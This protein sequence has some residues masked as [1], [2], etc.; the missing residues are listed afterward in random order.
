VRPVARAVLASFRLLLAQSETDAARLADLAG[1]AVRCVGNLKRAAPPLPHDDAALTAVRARIA[2]R[3]VWL[4]ASTHPG[5]EAM[6][7]AAHTRL[8]SRHP[9]LV[10]VIVPRHPTRGAAIR[11]ALAAT[12]QGAGLRS[13][14]SPLGEDG[15]YVADT[16]GELGLWYRL[17]DVAF[18]GGSL[19]PHGGQNPLEGARLGCALVYGPAMANFGEFAGGLVQAGAAETV[20][21]ADALVETVDRLLADPARR[22]AMAAAGA[23]YAAGGSEVVAAV[24]AEL[25]P[26]LGALK[27]P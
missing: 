3:P 16:L 24:A 21:D 4:A 26:Y 9:G 20:A 17:A 12:G 18:V 7:A 27:H 11:D 23:R 25:A 6:I 14:G 1:A 10:T 15:L 8:V 13:A 5:E 19:V 2:G 22:R